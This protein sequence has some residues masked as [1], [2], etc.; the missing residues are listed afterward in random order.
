MASGISLKC[1]SFKCN[2]FRIC[3][4]PPGKLFINNFFKS[5]LIL[6]DF[7]IQIFSFNYSYAYTFIFT[8]IFFS[9]A[10]TLCVSAIL[11]SQK[12]SYPKF[13]SVL[14]KKNKCSGR[15]PLVNSKRNY[16]PTCER[17]FA[18]I[19][20]WNMAKISI[21]NL[22]VWKFASTDIWKC[23]FIVIKLSAILW[24]H[25]QQLVLFTSIST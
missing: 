9:L 12:H 16:S 2:W 20:L 15:L 10:F 22:L 1:W 7:I 14:V 17:N 18:W 25:S 5:F 11:W 19:I 4:I 8:V 13:W 3:Q 24:Q 23:W 21:S 6:K